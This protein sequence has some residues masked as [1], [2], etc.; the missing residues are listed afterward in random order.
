L[1]L[2]CLVVAAIMAGIA[3]LYVSGYFKGFAAYQKSV[4]YAIAA[5]VSLV[6]GS[7][8]LCGRKSDNV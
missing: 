7:I 3:C 6:V 5:V 1:G 8:L 4:S 2:I